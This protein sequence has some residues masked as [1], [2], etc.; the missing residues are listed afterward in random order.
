[1]KDADAT[2]DVDKPLLKEPTAIASNAVAPSDNQGVQ[3]SLYEVKILSEKFV[4]HRDLL[5]EQLKNIQLST[6]G[7]THRLSRYFLVLFDCLDEKWDLSVENLIKFKTKCQ[8][9]EVDEEGNVSQDNY[10]LLREYAE[11]LDFLT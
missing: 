8:G 4:P 5:L 1:M 3:S 10:L 9:V 7:L 11:G 2:L 6:E